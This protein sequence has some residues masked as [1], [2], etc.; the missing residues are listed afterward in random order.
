MYHLFI[1]EFEF[2][3]FKN[4]SK[5]ALSFEDNFNLTFHIWFVYNTHFHLHIKT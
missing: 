2:N 4:N 5:C 3:D 1:I